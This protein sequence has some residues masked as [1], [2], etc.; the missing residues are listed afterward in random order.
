LTV[1]VV[2]KPKLTKLI[3]NGPIL[4]IDAALAHAGRSVRF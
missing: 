4:S 3:S 2:G 1:C